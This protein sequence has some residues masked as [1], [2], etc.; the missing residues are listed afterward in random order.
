MKPTKEEQLEVLK[1]LRESL[2]K[3]PTWRYTGFCLWNWKNKEER[4]F[5]IKLL[6]KEV[7]FL[8]RLWIRIMTFL[9]VFYT[10]YP[11][12]EAKPRLKLVN[13]AIKRLEK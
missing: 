10:W 12:R 7:F 5:Y 1:E 4:K 3:Y 8:R 6:R 2:E 13:K 11:L 9:D